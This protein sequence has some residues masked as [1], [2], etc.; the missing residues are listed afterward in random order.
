MGS[1]SSG[2][3]TTSS[4]AGQLHYQ[5]LE[6]ALLGLVEGKALHWR[7]EEMAV[8]MLLSMITYDT[9]PSPLSTLLYFSST[10]PTS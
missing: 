3:A 4:M 6:T 5:A 10:P 9:T 2:L 1:K 7:H 8:G